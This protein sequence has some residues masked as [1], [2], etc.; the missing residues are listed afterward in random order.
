MRCDPDLHR[1]CDHLRPLQVTSC[2]CFDSLINY[3]VLWFMRKAVCKNNRQQVVFKKKV[4]NLKGV[5]ARAVV[6]VGS[7]VH[8]C[9]KEPRIKMSTFSVVNC[10]Q[11]F[12]W[13]HWDNRKMSVALRMVSSVAKTWSPPRALGCIGERMRRITTCNSMC[14]LWS[15]NPSMW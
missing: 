12:W 8:V 15:M 3:L 14:V 10:F 9:E 7:R 5:L 6:P 2:P 13:L 4:P 1:P 11:P